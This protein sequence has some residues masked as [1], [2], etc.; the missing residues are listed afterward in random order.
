MDDK[1]KAE[2][3]MNELKNYNVMK[4]FI[5]VDIKKIDKYIEYYNKKITDCDV[6]LNAGNAKGVEYGYIP[7]TAVKEPV[8]SIL[9]EQEK[10]ITRRDEL[11]AMKEKDIYGFKA[12][13]K[14]IEECLDRLDDDWEREFVKK[15]YCNNEQISS[16]LNNFPRSR[17]SLY[18]DRKKIIM[19]M[20]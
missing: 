3:L 14:Y 7:T 5:E 8:L 17:S 12:R 16:I 4:R 1:E 11:I 15:Y 19:K 10:Y 20:V 2:Y 9:A 6:R 13:V 18:D